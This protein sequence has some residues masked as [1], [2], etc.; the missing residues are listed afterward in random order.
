M[1]KKGQRFFYKGICFDY[2]IELC[3]YMPK[4]NDTLVGANFKRICLDCVWE[5]GGLITDFISEI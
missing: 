5:Q 4:N 3:D 1:F 2:V